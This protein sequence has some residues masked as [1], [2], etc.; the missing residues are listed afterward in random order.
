VRELENILEHAL[1]ICRG[2]VIEPQ[3]LP[4]ALQSPPQPPPSTPAAG[5]PPRNLPETAADEPQRLREALAR[6]GGH[7]GQAAR[8]LG[9]DRT[10][11]W[12]KLKRYG[13]D[14]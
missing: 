10:T 14:A 5:P 12:R 7:R 6:H 4:L 3:H 9:M 13:I 1:I 11:L 2:R 8:S